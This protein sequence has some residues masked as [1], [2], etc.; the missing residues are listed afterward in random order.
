MKS[1]KNKLQWLVLDIIKVNHKYYKFMLYI[2]SI[3]I[4]ISLTN[5]YIKNMLLRYKN[6][7]L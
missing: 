3:L 6:K 7:K 1:I 5:S 4:V 2:K